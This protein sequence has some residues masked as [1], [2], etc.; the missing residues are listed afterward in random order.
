MATDFS[1]EFFIWSTGKVGARFYV[2]YA[3]FSLAQC[4]N[5]ESNLKNCFINTNFYGGGSI[6][7]VADTSTSTLENCTVNGNVYAGGYSASIPTIPVRDGGFSTIPKFNNQSGM[8][9][10][11]VFSGT[12]D[13]DWTAGTLTEN[14]TALNTA[15]GKHEIFTDVD[16]ETLGQVRTTILTIKGSSTVGESVYGGGEESAVTGDTKVTLMGSTQVHGNVFGGGYEGPVGG[17]TEVILKD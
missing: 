7:K 1:Y 10:P 13:F 12:T 5:V 4:H 17:N 3:S 2:K 6:G 11:G 9:E 16:L 15:D 8:F 14:A